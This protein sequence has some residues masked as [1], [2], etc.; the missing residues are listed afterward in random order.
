MLTVSAGD[1]VVIPAG[2]GDCNKGQSGDLLV[3]GAYPGGADDDIR[4]GD[5]AEIDAAR[6]AIAGVPMPSTDPVQGA[7]GALSRLW[8]ATRG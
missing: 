8:A 2:V 1:V 6:R 4:R 5:P 3:I 7:A